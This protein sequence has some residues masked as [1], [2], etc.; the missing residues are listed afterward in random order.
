MERSRVEA[1]A[2]ADQMLAEG[3]YEPDTPREQLIQFYFDQHAELEALVARELA[4]TPEQKLMEGPDGPAGR[5]GWQ[6]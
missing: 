2:W 4:K 3:L 6:G 5:M 1:E